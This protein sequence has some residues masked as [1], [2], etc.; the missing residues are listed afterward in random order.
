[1]AT[2]IES[3]A[4]GTFTIIDTVETPYRGLAETRTGPLTR[5]EMLNFTVAR[6]YE[7]IQRMEESISRLERLDEDTL[8]RSR[9]ESVAPEQLALG[10]ES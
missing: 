6:I 2:R 1:M 3:N 10:F 8:S 7:T 4:D 5:D 9:L